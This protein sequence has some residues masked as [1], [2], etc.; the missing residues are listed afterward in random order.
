MVKKQKTSP[1]ISP[2]AATGNAGPCFEA[3]VGAY[4]LLALVANSEPRGLPGATTQR[5]QFQQA[6]AGCP[7]DDVVVQAVG[8]DGSPAT[9][10]L[11]AKRTLDFTR[12]DAQFKNIVRRM[13]LAA[14]KPEFTSTRY[15]LAVAIARSSTRIEQAC[16]EVLHW[17]RQQTDATTFEANINLN[18]FASEPMRDFVAVFRENLAAAGAP[19]DADTVWQLLR[20]FN[21]LVFD[22]ETPGSDYEH[23]ARERGR[24]ALVADQASRAA[25]LWP[26]LATTA[27]DLARAGGDIDRGELKRRL[28]EPYGLLFGEAADLR[29]VNAKLAAAAHDALGDIK[30]QVG[31]VRLART[32]TIACAE[33]LLEQHRSLEIAGEPGVGKS[34][35]LKHLAQRLAPEG[36]IIVI[37]PGRIVPG[38][39]MAMADVLG[40]PGG[41]TRDQLFNELGCCGGA[42]LFVDN[43]DQIDDEGDWATIRD[44]LR[45]V[46]TS[47]GWRAVVTTRAGNDAWKSRLP[48]DIVAAGLATLP[49][50]EISDAETAVL[51]AANPALSALLGSAHPARAIA[52]NLFHLSQLMEITASQPQSAFPL[53][54]ETDL[55]RAWWRFGGGRDDNG[56]LARLKI[57]RALGTQVLAHPGR[58]AFPTDQCAAGIV[59]ELLQLKGL[60]EVRQGATITFRHDVQRDWTIGMLLD[61]QPDL[62]KAL[63]L[64][65]PVPGALSRGME[66][67]AK[68]ALEADP[69]GT[70]WLALLAAVEQD[71]CH[72]SWRRPILLALPRSERAVELLQRLATALLQDKG[73]RL[74]EI[75]RL[76]MAVDSEPLAKVLARIQP[77]FAIPQGAETVVIPKGTSW[78]WLVIWITARAEDM[79]SALMPD[80][81]KFL[82]CWLMASQAQASPINGFIIALLFKW[83]TR[84]EKGMHPM[85]FRDMREAETNDLDFPH[86]RDVRDDIRTTCFA[87][88]HL[89]PAA[90]QRYLEALDADKVRHDEAQFILRGPGSLARAAPVAFVDFALAAL[91]EKDDPDDP[92]ARRHDVLGPFGVHDG[93]CSPAAPAQGP[94][95]DLLDH[96]PAEGLRL[97]RGVVEH[98]TA[99]RHLQYAKARRPVPTM[100]IP[101]P[102]GPIT[103]AGDFNTY[104][105]GRSGMPSATAGSALMALEA[106]GHRQIENGRVFAEVLHDVLGPSGSS[107]AFVSVAVDLAL[108]HWGA[109]RELVWPLLATPKLLQWDSA[110]YIRDI[111]GADRL[112]GFDRDPPMAR[113]KRSD[114]DARVSRRSQLADCIGDF[115]FHGPPETLATLRAALQQARD[116]IAQSPDVDGDPINGLLPTAERALRMTDSQHWMLRK[117]QRP[118]GTEVEGWQFQIA[119][120]EAAHRA[121]A[122]QRSVAS[123]QHFN[124]RLQLQ[125]A[126][127]QPAKSTPE[128]V[129]EGLRWAK[130]QPAAP[131]PQ[132]NDDEERDDFDQDWDRRAIVMAAALAARDY[133]G[134]DRRQVADWAL[135]ILHGAAAN[136]DQ[137]YRGN[138]QIQYS[139]AALATLGFIAYYRRE[140]TEAARDVLLDLAAHAHPAVLNA[141]ATHFADLHQLDAKVPRALV[142]II[143]ASAIYPAR[144][145]EDDEDQQNEAASKARIADAIAAEKNWLRVAGAEPSWPELPPWLTRPRRSF[146]IGTW[147][148][149]HD[150]PEDEPPAPELLANEHRLGNLFG[151]LIALTVSST[152]PWVVELAT[153]LMAWTRD[154]EGPDGDDHSDRDHLPTTWNAHYFD[155]L[156]ILSVDLPHDRV[157]KL[158]LEHMASFTDE[159]FHDAAGTFLRGF[160]RSTLATDTSTPDNPA[161]V[162]AFLA[163]RIRHSR[164]FR[165]LRQEKSIMAETHLG[166]A[167]NAL[168]Y[169]PSRWAHH[170]KASIPQRWAGL[171][172]VMPTLTELVKDA[173]ASGYVATA[174]LTL[175]ESSPC[176]TLLPSVVA[177]MSAWASAYG[178]D[179]N[180]WSEKGIGTRACA[181]IATSLKED[182]AA[183]LAAISFVGQELTQCLDVLIR[184]GVPQARELEERLA[185]ATYVDTPR[186]VA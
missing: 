119:P 94:F 51:T 43:I 124:I 103:F 10:E 29:N 88:A 164:C 75:M 58:A 36:S 18:G 97:V 102:N 45:G 185:D 59:T 142:R 181:W 64:D 84:I 171:P 92:Y 117:G 44:L 105:W 113:V 162:R 170:G 52:R 156:G 127:L 39:W 4:Y 54:S 144:N 108:S 14:Q 55:A 160:D 101:F 20:R 128:I 48:Q 121:A 133:E 89:E 83:L 65:R 31:G 12:S 109:S 176:G 6:P 163:E 78:T 159:A 23:R 106:W 175:V 38:G 32:H 91:I 82:Q 107:V 30:D 125:A 86:I 95:F 140:Q 184:A 63:A 49:I 182:T 11:Q 72:W 81:A 152:P 57:L 74:A 173:P 69:T 98:A 50:E 151:H 110:R 62:L 167:L 166:D 15:E 186:D 139:A 100:T 85:V 104:H 165:R 180:F 157:Q 17:A 111:T 138:D 79:P 66:I 122:Q 46:L 70:Q 174:F 13:W 3:K 114:L 68:L 153:H 168:F 76:V 143:M 120:D 34:A 80:M 145:Y 177:A 146:R 77:T 96:A 73:R 47:P 28:Q 179:A 33:A 22:F 118:D 71:G 19:T 141:L 115:T 37:A 158:F 2:P 126:L 99:W 42:T 148:T 132:A 27:L 67:A 1:P 178:I 21:I 154:A 8:A 53:A 9:L 56:R 60:R 136:T 131:D 161:A 150:E 130:A 123:T 41:V 137:T 7:M 112:L 169:Q 90:A 35:V 25:E 155:F 135:E 40:C 87:L 16:Q 24:M 26:I 5:V 147:S 129:A 61:E 149:E 93:L 116:L 183:S 172:E 134:N